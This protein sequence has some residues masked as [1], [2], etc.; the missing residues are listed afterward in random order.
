M[1]SILHI[2][3]KTLFDGMYAKILSHLQQRL[4]RDLVFINKF[5]ISIDEDNVTLGINNRIPNDLT[6]FVVLIK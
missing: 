1:R 5:R 4:Q 6:S 3:L 2:F